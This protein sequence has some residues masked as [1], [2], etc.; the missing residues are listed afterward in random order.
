MF[1]VEGRT[2]GVLAALGLLVSMVVLMDRLSEEADSNEPRLPAAV[3]SVRAAP[4]QMPRP[5]ESALSHRLGASRPSETLALSEKPNA[6]PRDHL[7][8]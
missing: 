1:I 8:H 4:L 3:T 7:G 5:D 2:L 6:H